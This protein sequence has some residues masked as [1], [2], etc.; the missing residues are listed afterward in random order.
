[1]RDAKPAGWI[2][3]SDKINTLQAATGMKPLLGQPGLDALLATPTG[4]ALQ[5]SI[6]KEAERT[7]NQ[8]RCANAHCTSFLP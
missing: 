8:L 6:K 1:M 7:K 3:W 4:A 2:K 5:K